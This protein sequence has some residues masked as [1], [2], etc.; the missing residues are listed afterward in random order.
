[1][2]TKL[3][4][5]LCIIGAGS[6]GLSI[7]A[8]AA[9]L[10]RK[11]VLIERGEMGGDCL[12]YGC[13]P[14]KALIAAA[15]HAKTITEAPQFGVFAGA[16]Q[17]DFAKTMAHVRDAIAAIAPHDSQE[18]F[19]KL[20]VKVIRD[21]AAFTGPREVKAGESVIRAKHF[22]IATGAK[23]VIPPIPGLDAAPYFTNETIFSNDTR[24]DHLLIIGAGPV[25]AEMAQAFRRLGSDVTMISASALLPKE[26][27]EAVEIVREAL[28]EDSVSIYENQKIDSVGADAAGVWITFGGQTIN[29]SHILVAAG[30]RAVYDDLDLEKA[31]VAVTD[32]RI[33]TNDRLQTAN[34]RIYAAGD[35]AGG[36]QFTHLAGD[37]ASTVIRNIVFKIPAA[38]RDALCPRATFTDPEIAAVGLSPDEALSRDPK[39]KIV[40][41]PFA[42]NDRAVAEREIKG[43]VKAVTD[44]KG[45]ILGACVVGRG[46][47]DLIHGYAFAIANKLTIRAFTNYIAPYPTRGEALKRAAGAWYTPALFSARTRALARLLAAFD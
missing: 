43:F 29:G 9:Q 7:A 11:V 13:V 44:A 23:A 18:R 26:D 39:A 28:K 2:T 46:A 17:I 34:K 47:G 35:A 21:S 22:V 1:M 45:R 19:A 10:G 27:P 14:S 6:A 5:D 42:E 8:G 32:G 36:A 31:G 38:R 3:A 41:W 16:P 15:A 25:G 4:A 12:N 20:G 40:R 30:R 24:P 33:E 37:H